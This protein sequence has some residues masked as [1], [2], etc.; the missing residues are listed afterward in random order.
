MAP[1]RRPTGPP[2]AV[3]PGSPHLGRWSSRTLLAIAAP[4]LIRPA[5]PTRWSA[6]PG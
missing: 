3:H 1:E 4:L 2:T 5:S 6:P